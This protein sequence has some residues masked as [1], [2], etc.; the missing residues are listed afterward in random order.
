MKKKN[1]IPMAALVL[2]FTL[3]NT[4]NSGAQSAV[5]AYQMSAATAGNDVAGASGLANEVR[6]IKPITITRLGVFDS[7]GDGIQGSAVITVQ[8]FQPS[9]RSSSLLLETLTFDAASP[10]ELSGGCRFKS[11]PRPVTLLPGRY[12]IAAGGF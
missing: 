9:A 3:G 8:L 4:A 6:V 12:I 7:D 1:A 2:A 10:G 11:L 5:T